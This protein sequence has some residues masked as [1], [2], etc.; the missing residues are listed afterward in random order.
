MIEE[1]SPSKEHSPAYKKKGAASGAPA[2]K[3]K[4][5]KLGNYRYY[6]ESDEDL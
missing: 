1:V 3:H 6:D 2:S 5:D 4:T